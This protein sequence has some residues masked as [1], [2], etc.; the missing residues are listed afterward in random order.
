MT[1]KGTRYFKSIQD[2]FSKHVL[3]VSARFSVSYKQHEF[4]FTKPLQKTEEKCL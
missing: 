4:I 3:H 2:T 1:Q